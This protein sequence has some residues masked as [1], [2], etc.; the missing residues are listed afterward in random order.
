MRQ[1]ALT[2]GEHRLRVVHWC[3]PSLPVQRQQI[4][5]TFLHQFPTL[6]PFQTSHEASFSCILCIQTLWSQSPQRSTGALRFQQVRCLASRNMLET[7]QRRVH[8]KCKARRSLSRS[9]SYSGRK[10]IPLSCSAYTDTA[11]IEGSVRMSVAWF[12]SLAVV[13]S[14]DITKCSRAPVAAETSTERGLSS[15]VVD[16]TARKSIAL[17]KVFSILS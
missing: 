13:S 11:V 4:S 2:D 15:R 16:S 8:R 14:E 17:D 9:R 5:P 1:F 12:V 7:C 10:T 6:P 3:T